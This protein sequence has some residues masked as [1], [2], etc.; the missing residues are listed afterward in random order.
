MNPSQLALDWT[1][2]PGISPP[3]SFPRSRLEAAATRLPDRAAVVGKRRV[4]FL[5]ARVWQLQDP[6]TDRASPNAERVTDVSRLTVRKVGV[7][8]RGRFAWMGPMVTV[9]TVAMIGGCAMC[10]DTYDYSPPVVGSTVDGGCPPSGRAG[11]AVSG[12]MVPVTTVPDDGI[13]VEP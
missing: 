7:M 8:T 10:D 9:M 2:A 11:S 6:L 13:V 5:G 12:G 4:S 1:A 3:H